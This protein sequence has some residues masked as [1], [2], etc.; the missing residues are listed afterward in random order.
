V[1]GRFSLGWLVVMS[2]LGAGCGPSPA[3]LSGAPDPGA[4]YAERCASCHG[5]KGAGDGFASEGMNPLP[6][7][8]RKLPASADDAYLAR[9]I[10]EGGP[11]L[12]KSDGMPGFPDLSG[13]PDHL[14]ALVSY[15]RT[16]SAS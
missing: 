10:V 16:L 14:N 5:A 1:S 11:A 7:D 4:L 12:G 13:H 9:I 2:A 15:L 3:P 6:S 8:L